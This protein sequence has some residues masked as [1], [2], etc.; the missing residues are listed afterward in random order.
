MKGLHASLCITLLKLQ[1]V[2]LYPAISK[3]VIKFYN[4]YRL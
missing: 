3:V 2:R 4:K 1:V